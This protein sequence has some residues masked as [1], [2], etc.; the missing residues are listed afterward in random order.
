MKIKP[1]ESIE[2]EYKGKKYYFCNES[3]EIEFKNN[4]EKYIKKEEG[5]IIKEKIKQIEKKKQEVESMG[6]LVCK[7][8]NFEM[9]LPM[10]CGKPMHQEGDQLVC[11]MGSSCGAQPIPE[12]H[13]AKMEVI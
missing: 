5:K 8:C 10:H 4:P 1:S 11:W 13:G 2:Y 9:K 12:H 6:K 7:K 3:C